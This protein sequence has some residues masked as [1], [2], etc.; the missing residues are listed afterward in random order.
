M[1]RAFLRRAI[2]DAARAGRGRVDGGAGVQEALLL[3][4]PRRIAGRHAEEV[5]QEVLRRGVLVEPPHQVGDGAVEV[6][7]L[8]HRGVEQEALRRVADGAR[9]VVRHAF[10]H[11]E[12]DPFPDALSR[13]QQQSVG[14][15]EE[16]VARHPEPHRAGVL[17]LAALVEHPLEIRI[18]LGLRAVGR[19]RPVVDLRVDLLH[20]QVGAL[21]DADLD[22]RA[23]GIDAAEG[24]GIELLLH[25]PRVGQV[26]LE[27]DAGLQPVKL[28]LV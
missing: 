13:P 18:D 7:A 12:L 27:H 23:A 1:G 22:P 2:L 10:E 16:V 11:L 15:V 28:R 17:R 26:G 5:V 9:L 21:D 25:R 14:D 8:H 6:L 20:R 4:F 3:A 19:E 24:P